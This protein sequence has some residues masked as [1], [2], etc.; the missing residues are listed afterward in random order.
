M[1]FLREMSSKVVNAAVSAL[2]TPDDA[3]PA[4][5]P[6]ATTDAEPE[7]APEGA[8][9][10]ALVAAVPDESESAGPKRATN[11]DMTA[12]GLSRIDYTVQDFGDKYVITP[13]VY[14]DTKGNKAK[15]TLDS[16][17]G[18]LTIQ[19]KQRLRPVK[20]GEARDRKAL[21][22]FLVVP[23]KVDL[24]KEPTVRH[25]TLSGGQSTNTLNI[26]LAK[27]P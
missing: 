15:V 24:T 11:I 7:A 21:G 1:N 17:T 19:P 25:Q 27:L 18:I 5:E 12:D 8:G 16:E 23:K 26:D 14:F 20:P 2:Q 10:A 13:Y 4:A 9:E 3:A 22:G 6:V